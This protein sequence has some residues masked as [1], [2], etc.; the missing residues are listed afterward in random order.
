LEFTLAGLPQPLQGTVEKIRPGAGS[1]YETWLEQ[2]SPEYASRELL[3]RLENA[4]QPEIM[5]IPG[6]GEFSLAPGKIMVISAPT[7]CA[8]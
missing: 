6:S 7:R 2:G 4:S 8:H 1:A 5:P 3:E